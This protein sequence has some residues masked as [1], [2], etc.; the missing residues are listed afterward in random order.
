VTYN[1][2]YA[3]KD[4]PVLSYYGYDSGANRI[5]LAFRGS[6][7]QQALVEALVTIL[8][9]SVPFPASPDA[10]INPFFLA[11]AT[12]LCD[13]MGADF[14]WL[15]SLLAQYPSA[16]VYIT[17]H[18]LGG[19]MA[20]LV[21]T[22]LVLKKLVSTPPVLYTF[23]QPRTGDG[24]F[25][26]LVTKSIP[27]AYRVVNANDPVPHVPP[28]DHTCVDC[29]YGSKCGGEYSCCSL[30]GSYVHHSTELWFPEGEYQ[31]GVMCGYK[32]CLGPPFGEDASCSDRYK[33]NP[34]IKAHSAYWNAL[35][36][37]CNVA[38]L[39]AQPSYN[40]LQPQNTGLSG[41][42]L[43][44]AGVITFLVLLTAGLIWLRYRARKASH[45]DD[46]HLLESY[47]VP[48]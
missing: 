11:G 9:K 4:F 31:N 16:E 20:S 44:G 25:A 17:G 2:N 19:A 3:S 46:F 27:R 6:V 36:G 22:E 30:T 34:D 40:T 38:P 32:E 28:C 10:L 14:G 26:A 12:G 7:D 39:G 45:I 18:S 43:V 29:N 24:K 35:S 41:T 13:A 8:E 5:V 33:L 42:L 1:I 37:Y 48:S 15:T 21:A 47:S 23:G